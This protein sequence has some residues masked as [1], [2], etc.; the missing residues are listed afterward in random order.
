MPEVAD[1]I[2]RKNNAPTPTADRKDVVGAPQ[3]VASLPNLTD[4]TI[5]AYVREEGMQA[6]TLDT[7]TRYTLGPDLT[8][9]TP[10]SGGGGTATGLQTL[11]TVVVVS[12][13]TAPTAGQ[14]LTATSGTA[15]DWETPGPGG[16]ISPLS[17]V[18][19]VDQN[20]ATPVPSQN[21]SQATPF[22]TITAALGVALAHG[23]TIYISPADYSIEGALTMPQRI[24]LIGM[25]TLPQGES[26]SF[27]VY[28]GDTI[29]GDLNLPAFTSANCTNMT[30]ANVAITDNSGF[31][32]TTS[33]NVFGDVTGGATNGVLVFNSSAIEGNNLSATYL[34]AK[35]CVIGNGTNFSI[36]LTNSAEADFWECTFLVGVTITFSGAPGVVQIDLLSCESW[37]KNKVT[38]V[39]GTLKVLGGD[40]VTGIQNIN[41]PD[42]NTTTGI[43]LNRI[44]PYPSKVKIGDVLTELPSSGSPIKVL[45]IDSTHFITIRKASVVLVTSGLNYIYQIVEL[46]DAGNL[47]D[48]NGI[49]SIDGVYDGTLYVWVAGY[50]TPTT[51]SYLW[52]IDTTTRARLDFPLPTNYTIQ[53]IEYSDG[54]VLVSVLDSND[55]LYKII[56]IDPTT[57]IPIAVVPYPTPTLVPNVRA[58]GSSPNFSWFGG[59]DSGTSQS[60]I[61]RFNPSLLVHIVNDTTNIETLPIAS[62]QATEEALLND[63]KAQFTA[64]LGDTNSHI[65]FDNA[66]GITAPDAAD[67]LGG[68]YTTAK[69]LANDLKAKVNGHLLQAGV[70]YHLDIANKITTADVVTDVGAP[71]LA[72][73]IALANA[74]GYATTN[75]AYNAH[76]TQV[77][78]LVHE[79]QTNVNAEISFTGA[80]TQSDVENLLNDLKVLYNNHRTEVGVHPINDT[81][82][83]VTAA[84]AGD[85]PGGPNY[86]LDMA[87]VNDLRVQINAHLIEAGVH[88]NNDTTNTIPGPA[89]SDDTDLAAIIARA[90]LIG[91]LIPFGGLYNHHL[92]QPTEFIDSPLTSTGVSN[93]TDIAFS[94]VTNEGFAIAMSYGDNTNPGVA[95][96][97]TLLG[98]D[99][100]ASSSPIG[101]IVRSW[102]IGTFHAG[103]KLVRY[104][105][106]LIVDDADN[107]I[108]FLSGGT[109]DEATVPYTLS[110][111]TG[112]HEGPGSPFIDVSGN[113]PMIISTP[114]GVKPTSITG[115]GT[116]PIRISYE[117]GDYIGDIVSTTG[118]LD[119]ENKYPM[120]GAFA[121]GPSTVT[122]TVDGAGG[123]HIQKIDFSGQSGQ[124]SYT[125]GSAG[126]LF[127]T[128]SVQ[129]PSITF[130]S[131]LTFSS[132]TTI[133][134]GVVNSRTVG[135]VALDQNFPDEVTRR[136]RVIATAI[137]NASGTTEEPDAG[138]VW[139]PPAVQIGSDS[140]EARISLRNITGL[141]IITGADLAFGI[142]A[143]YF[144]GG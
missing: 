109:P 127:G 15:A 143:Y 29:I 21:G 26:L 89:L 61:T 32:S 5:P 57:G 44:R 110:R 122:V 78:Q 142:T 42:N 90:N 6:T 47:L 139:N 105:I 102:N 144:S 140:V 58:S 8:T 123:G 132:G 64:H 113:V 48:L 2:T 87:L 107:L 11:T 3:M 67:A 36:T 114:S 56:K 50:S 126:D 134:A 129:A 118:L 68:P 69:D 133:N 52:K 112:I 116:N 100:T 10:E 131:R 66:N 62:D 4:G 1:K 31:F 27:D 65:H 96:F 39:N 97:D 88:F 30:I 38:L 91:G 80:V 25:D 60:K 54:I 99:G 86:P 79:L 59:R 119:Q 138:L 41:I 34:D 85:T 7:G 9:W 37:F 45:T 53:A 115:G 40:A 106:S 19:Y 17:K 63:L 18:F 14:V 74:I 77:R 71:G 94:V 13:A 84:D 33:C 70:H 75:G 98:E 130:H 104:P 46:K 20:T 72:Q 117:T 81:V 101:S 108:W 55:S 51:T 141:P 49:A 135:M 43:D 16:T 83:I 95:Y 121:F 22:S 73:I 28:P 92:V 23:D 120:G 82:N 137:P 125:A 12:G 35:N 76:R 128:L 103:P 136:W 111:T 93:T 24:N 124:L